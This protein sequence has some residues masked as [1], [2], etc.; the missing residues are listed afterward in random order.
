MWGSSPKKKEPEDEA[1]A[2]YH[3][4]YKGKELHCQ[5]EYTFT[6]DW[7][8]VTKLALKARDER[9]I[10][11]GFRVKKIATWKDGTVE[12][13]WG[14]AIPTL[15][16]FVLRA[17]EFVWSELVT[18]DTKNQSLTI[19][20]ENKNLRSWGTFSEESSWTKSGMNTTKFLKKAYCTKPFFVPWKL[21]ESYAI[22]YLNYAYQSREDENVIV[23]QYL[24]CSKEEGN[25]SKKKTKKKGEVKV[26]VGTK[27]GVL[28]KKKIANSNDNQ[29]CN[30]T[31]PTI[32]P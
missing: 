2:D 26:V 17:T 6:G 12:Y 22:K 10:Q 1:T 7:N 25:K 9:P 27:E 13:E 4:E 14:W 8:T 11:P 15:L 23:M 20:M 28:I 31:V 32:S 24:K 19:V 30:E 21:V 3:F 16:Q 5:S 29:E 18:C